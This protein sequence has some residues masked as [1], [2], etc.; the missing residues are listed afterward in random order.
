MKI[1]FKHL[2]NILAVLIMASCSS[3]LYK[4]DISQGSYPSDASI[5]KIKVGMTKEEVTSILGS[6]TLVNPIYPNKWAYVYTFEKGFNIVEKKKLTLD[7]DNNN[8]KKIN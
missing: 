1:I 6:P 8:L 7:F 2:A 4:Q 5:G 3:I